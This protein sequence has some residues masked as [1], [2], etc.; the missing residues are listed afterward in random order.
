MSVCQTGNVGAVADRNYTGCPG[1]RRKPARLNIHVG[2]P[3]VSG[4]LLYHQLCNKAKT[5]CKL[6]ALLFKIYETV[7]P[8]VMV[9]YCG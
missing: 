3:V 2:R 1:E 8:L 6:Q 5:S 4:P 7:P 9:H